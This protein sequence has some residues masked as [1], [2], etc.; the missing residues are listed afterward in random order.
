MKTDRNFLDDPRCD[1]AW[2]YGGSTGTRFDKVTESNPD[3]EETYNE[4]YY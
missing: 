2:W 1:E 3:D 4:M